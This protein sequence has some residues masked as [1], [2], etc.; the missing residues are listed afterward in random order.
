MAAKFPLLFGTRLLLVYNAAIPRRQFRDETGYLGE[1]EP[2]AESKDQRNRTGHE[3]V[4]DIIS[5]SAFV[6]RIRRRRGF[7]L[8]SQARDQIILVPDLAGAIGRSGAELAFA[9]C[10]GR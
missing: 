2:P 6:R 7:P 1:A 10:P 5:A 4:Q 8:P 9:R 3:R